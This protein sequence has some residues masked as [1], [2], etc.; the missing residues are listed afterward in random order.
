MWSRMP[1]LS[2]T[3]EFWNCNPLPSYPS[4]YKKTLYFGWWS[5]TISSMCWTKPPGVSA[6]KRVLPGV[7]RCRNNYVNAFARSNFPLSIQC[8]GQINWT[9]SVEGQSLLQSAVTQRIG[10]TSARFVKDPPNPIY[11]PKKKG[12]EE[13][14]S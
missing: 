8:P 7:I 12:G 4:I 6:D 10:I 5:E 2:A 1:W 14:E 9:E 13:H 11:R 3:I